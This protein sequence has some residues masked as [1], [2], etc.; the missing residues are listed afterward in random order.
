MTGAATPNAFMLAAEFGALGGPP[1]LLAH[2]KPQQR[3][4][5]LGRGHRRVI[6]S[7]ETLFNQGAVHDGIFL[8]ESGLIKVFYSAP[9]G[10]EI[11]LAYWYPG[12]FVGGPEVLGGGKHVWSGVAVRNSS[13]VALSSGDLLSLIQQVPELAIGII[14]GLVFKGKCYSAMAQMLGTRSVSERLTQLLRSLCQLYGLAEGNA[15]TINAAYSHQD[16]AN[17]VGATRQW[18]G[19]TLKRL[20]QNGIVSVQK[21][22]LVVLRPDLLV[23]GVDD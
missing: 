20:Q 17:M 7:G 16:L 13:V 19:E 3:D 22:R 12:N 15:I 10:R 11:T 6:N 18:V 23:R 21:R 5:V 9:S 4:L 1:N 2:L 8:I 14:D